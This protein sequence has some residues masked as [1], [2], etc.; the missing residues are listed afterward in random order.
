MD[1]YT[2]HVFT[3]LPKVIDQL[4]LGI[5]YFENIE[6]DTGR[7]VRI[8]LNYKTFRE[9]TQY[10]IAYYVNKGFFTMEQ[11]ESLLAQLASPDKENWM[12]AFTIIDNQKHKQWDSNQQKKNT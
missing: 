3:Q 2:E 10:L 12:V 11:R 5:M 1:R 4:N 7:A 6:N 9:Q 8:D